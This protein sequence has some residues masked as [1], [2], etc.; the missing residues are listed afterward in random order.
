MFKVEGMILFLPKIFCSRPK[1]ETSRNKLHLMAELYEHYGWLILL[2][3]VT[4]ELCIF[5]GWVM[6]MLRL[7]YTIQETSQSHTQHRSNLRQI[8][9]SGCR[10]WSWSVREEASLFQCHV[11]WFDIMLLPLSSDSSFCRRRKS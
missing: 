7:A 10:L 6:H 2:R 11:W 3:C 8:Y 9:S 1:Y 4:T 5:Y